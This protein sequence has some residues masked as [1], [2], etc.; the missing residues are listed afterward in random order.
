MFIFQLKSAAPEQKARKEELFIKVYAAN[1]QIAKL[2]DIDD[3]SSDGKIRPNLLVPDMIMK[4]LLSFCTKKGISKDGSTKLHSSDLMELKQQ[5]V[6]KLRA[7]NGP[8]PKEKYKTW[9]EYYD[10]VIYPAINE[11]REK[12]DSGF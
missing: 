3:S 2:A 11:S 6:D 9:G 12:P 7:N 1:F 8:A 4:D 5:I 10:K